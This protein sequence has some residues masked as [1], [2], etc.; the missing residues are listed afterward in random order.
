LNLFLEHKEKCELDAFFKYGFKYLAD[1]Y[2]PN[3]LREA[4]VI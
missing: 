3:K 4:G 2:L 1:T